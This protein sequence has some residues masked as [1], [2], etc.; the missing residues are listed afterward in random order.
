MTYNG[1]LH[2]VQGD[3]YH[4]RQWGTI[5]WNQVLDRWYWSTGHFGNY[6]IDIGAQIT[7]S[8]YDHQQLQSMYLARGN[9]V[10]VE[11]MEDIIVE[12]SGSNITG[13]PG[14]QRTLKY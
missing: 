5:N 7:S 9:Q 1:Q 13:P 6:T 8:F 12:A 4:D 10:S 14:L 11:T 3:G 2:R